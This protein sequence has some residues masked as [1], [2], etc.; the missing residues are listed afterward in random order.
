MFVKNKRDKRN[1]RENFI[2]AFVKN[3]RDKRNKREQ[4]YHSL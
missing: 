1:K 2:P 3:K 4:V